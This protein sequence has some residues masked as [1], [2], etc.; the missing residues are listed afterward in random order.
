MGGKVSEVNMNNGTEAARRFF[1][2][3]VNQRQFETGLEILTEDCTYVS[4]ANTYYGCEDC[5]TYMR[6]L[7]DAW[8][9]FHVTVHD[10][11]GEG[12]TVTAQITVEATPVKEFLGIPPSFQRMK[13][14]ATAYFK[15]RDGMIKSLKIEYEF[16]RLLSRE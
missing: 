12:D 15:I 14:P 4:P 3:V 13:L 9:D 10:M 11:T 1:D 5:V 2:E 6:Q 7:F 8:S 16:A